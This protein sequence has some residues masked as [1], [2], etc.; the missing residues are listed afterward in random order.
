LNYHK[1]PNANKEALDQDIINYV[2][3]NKIKILDLTWN[4]AYNFINNYAD[5]EYYIQLKETAKLVHFL[6]EYKPWSPVYPNVT[7]EGEYFKYLR[8][9]PYYN[10]FIIIYNQERIIFELEKITALLSK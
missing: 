5:K 6:S 8:L 1:L 9:T 4:H 2:L 10:D 7:R 3:Q